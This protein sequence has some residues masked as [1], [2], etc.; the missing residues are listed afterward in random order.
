[1][2][3]V[4][5]LPWLAA[6]LAADS[7]HARHGNVLMRSE[8][9]EH[10][11]AADGL[12]VSGPTKIPIEGFTEPAVPKV[13]EPPRVPQPPS[14]LKESAAAIKGRGAAASSYIPGGGMEEPAGAAPTH[15]TS[16]DDAPPPPP[17]PPV[18]GDAPAG[19]AP[20][21]QVAATSAAGQAP[22]TG[23]Y[24]HPSFTPKV[25]VLPTKDQMKP[26]DAEPET[27]KPVDEPSPRIE[28]S[29]FSPPQK[30][31][32]VDVSASSRD[33]DIL[34]AKVQPRAEFPPSEEDVS[35]EMFRA[36]D[37]V[38]SLTYERSP[39]SSRLMNHD[40]RRRLEVQDYATLLLLLVAFAFT[41]LLSSSVIYRLAEDPSPVTFYTDPKYTATA[42]H[43]RLT[44]G[45]MDREGWLRAFNT[46]PQCA[47][48]RI[49]GKS[50]DFQD[51]HVLL[52]TG[53]FGALASQMRQRAAASMTRRPRRRDPRL[54]AVDPVLFD[55]S[56]DLTPF[57][58]GDGRLATDEDVQTLENHLSSS[59]PL[60]VILLRKQVE[61]PCWEDVATNIKQRLRAM[62]FTGDVE[63]YLEAK[64]EVLVY[65][66]LPWQ[67]FVRSRL[68]Q[69][70]VI[71]SIV[72]WIFWAPYLRWRMRTV[73]VESRF[74]ISL[75]LARY[76]EHLSEGLSA[77][78]GFSP[79]AL[80]R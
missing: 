58:T 12:L 75:D 53:Q 59:N 50:R 7:A 68:T 74:R 34:G 15:D 4:L 9:S 65:R 70:L 45:A 72:G 23:D 19:A 27:D 17:P 36:S 64:E 42:V 31:K 48:M 14:L 13:P 30:W 37:G 61:W 16:L 46:Q 79:A 69:V 66:N 54:P 76:W 52:R 71:L 1:M 47:R 18:D 60:E 67:N 6:G 32:E 43:S 29:D 22:D 56:L 78:E 55:V 5:Q 33:S 62:G 35:E 21:S 20:P 38:G 3:I 25:P 41:L 57:V 10:A 51:W 63:V 44:C 26:E 49:V 11:R 24:H 77:T 28:E 8:G 2:L 73:H 40:F 80:V 39:T